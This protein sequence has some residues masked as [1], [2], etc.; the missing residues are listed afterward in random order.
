MTSVSLLCA[1]RSD[2]AE[3]I[4]ANVASRL[5]HA[6]WAQPFTDQEGFDE[7]FG[8]LF[9]D[10]NVGFV[11]RDLHSGRVIGVTNLSQIFRQGFQNAYLGYY[12]MVGFEGRGL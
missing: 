6:P 3:L 4:G 5:H 1:K 12:G 8:T 2:A 7:W 11:V 9:T 10:A